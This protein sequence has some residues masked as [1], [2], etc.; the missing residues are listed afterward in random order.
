LLSLL[1]TLPDL[2]AHPT[3]GVARHC[4]KKIS[5]PARRVAQPPKIHY[6][7]KG[8]DFKEFDVLMP[9]VFSGLDS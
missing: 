2:F 5:R 8:C 9:G 4:F 3:A 6:G 7:E 1:L